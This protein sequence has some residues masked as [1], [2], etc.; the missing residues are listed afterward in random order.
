MNYTL[1]DFDNH[2]MNGLDFCKKA[3]GLFEDIR[4]SSNGVE[5]LHL[6]KGKLEKKLIEELLP[7]ARYIQARY[8]HGRQLKVRWKDGTQKYDA[9]LLSSGAL[10]DVNLSPKSQYVEV[11]TAVHENDHIERSILN[12][13]GHVF[14][15]KGI[16]KDSQTGEY[17]SQPYCYTN[18]ELSEDLAQKILERIKAKTKIRYPAQTTLLI[19]CFL[20]TIF[21]EDEWEYAI[22]K[23]KVSGIEHRFREIFIFDSNH[24]YA[25]TLYGKTGGTKMQK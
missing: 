2:L 19:Q 8:S 4:R 1:A 13:N 5:R 9:R 3:Y 16:K 6:R 24:H 17:I 25:A 10:V 14:S 22:Q 18:D 7:I 15:V 12:K 11:T 20:D 23:V 21:S